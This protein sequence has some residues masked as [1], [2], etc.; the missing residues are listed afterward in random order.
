MNDL[1]DLARHLYPELTVLAAGPLHPAAREYERTT[2]ALLNAYVSGSLGGL[3]VRDVAD[4]ERGLAEEPVD[5]G[6]VAVPA[7]VAQRV[8]DTLVAGVA[9]VVFQ[10]A[11]PLV[12]SGIVRVVERRAADDEL[13]QNRA[14][15]SYLE[16]VNQLLFKTRYSP[17]ANFSGQVG[18]AY[19]ELAEEIADARKDSA[20]RKLA[21]ELYVLAYN[22]DI[23][24]G[25]A[26]TTATETMKATT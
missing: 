24:N 7:P 4:L 15:A 22:T 8:I 18:A 16:D 11:R 5:I 17:Q 13:G 1:A 10:A 21:T 23:T 3:E 25:G 6:I 9:L 19:L 20:G 12:R 14:V 2:F 26:N